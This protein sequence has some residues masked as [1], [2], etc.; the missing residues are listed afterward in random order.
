MRILID[1]GHPAH[2]HNYR[3]LALEMEKKG[4]KVFWAVK[5]IDIAKRLLDYYGFNYILLP[6]KSDSLVGKV[7]KQILYDI[8]I[9]IFC[10]R[11]KIDLAIGTSV[12]VAHISKIS[13]VKSIVFD[14]DDDDIQPLISRFVNPYADV[15]LSPEALIGKRKRTDTIYYAGYHELAYLHPIRF[16]PDPDILN[17]LGIKQGEQ[18]FIMRFNVFKAHHD[19]GVKGLSLDQKLK[20]VDILKPYGKIFITTERNTETELKN[21]QLK[22]NPEKIHSLIFY[23]TMLL[24]DSQTMTSEAAILGTPAIKCNTFAGKLSV[25]D[26]LE[27]KYNLC[28]SFLPEQFD[29]MVEKIKELI[30]TPFLKEEWSLRR[31]KMLNDKIDVTSFWSWLIDSYP[32]SIILLKENPLYQNRFR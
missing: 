17:E 12:S 4:H 18:F 9:L 21:Y 28:Y 25:P 26:E 10:K 29:S 8:I 22:I 2:V 14:D 30:D 5:E 16:S 31:D 6:G 32:R 20:L 3:N 27:I 11:E 23:A 19:Q 15:L 7:W 13:K 1:I 24:G